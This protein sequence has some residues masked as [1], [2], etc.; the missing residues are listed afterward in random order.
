MAEPMAALALGSNLGDS[1]ATLQGAVADLAR[2]PGLELVAVS[3]VYETDP[4]GGPEQPVYLNAVVLARCALAPLDLLAQTQR[5]EADWQRTREVRWG[6]RTLDI[7]V[8]AVGDLVMT[9]GVLDLPHP[10][11]HERGFVLVPWHDVDGGARIPGQGAVADLLAAVD[12]SGV[13]RA[14]V[15][16]A[17]G[18]EPSSGRSGPS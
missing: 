16:L 10:R 13:R 3:P 12:V 5:I 15:T 9:T 1:A 17:L 7:D 18:S 11:A 2:V 14:N 8:L 6:P 4:V